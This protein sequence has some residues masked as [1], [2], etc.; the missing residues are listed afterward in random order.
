MQGDPR[1]IVDRRGFVSASLAGGTSVVLTA[2]ASSQPIGRS[3]GVTA[4]DAT[5]GTVY[6]GDVLDGKRV[7]SRL[8]V[9]DLEPGK[10][11]LLY[12]QGV[13]SPIGMALF[14]TVIVVKG[15]RPGKRGVLVSGVHGDEISPI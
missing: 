14:V 12:F 15:L 4:P 3:A 9:A 10:K 2:P 7:V 1:T 13:R 11:H 8:D 6:T 5:T